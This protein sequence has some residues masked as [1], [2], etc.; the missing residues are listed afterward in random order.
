MS[1]YRNFFFF[2][3]INKVLLV[4]TYVIS[5]FFFLW[6]RALELENEAFRV[7]RFLRYGDNRISRWNLLEIVQHSGVV[8]KRTADSS[9][10]ISE[11]ESNLIGTEVNFS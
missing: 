2:S 5:P 8:R 11:T 10:L 1:G 7:F 3:M 4:V 6:H 9:I